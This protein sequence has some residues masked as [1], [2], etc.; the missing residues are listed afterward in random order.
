ML[1]IM[2]ILIAPLDKLGSDKI[3]S[4]IVFLS[5]EGALKES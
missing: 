3:T 1:I 2:E 5:P 4:G